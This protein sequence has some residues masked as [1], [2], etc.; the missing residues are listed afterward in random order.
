VKAQIILYKKLIFILMPVLILVIF[1]EVRARDMQNGFSV[2]KSMF[3][4]DMGNTE[5]LILGSSHGYFSINPEVF[6]IHSY[7]LAF[8]SQ[9]LY[10]D[11]ELLDK[12]K[13]SLKNLRCIMLSVSYFSL[14]YDLNEAPERWRKYFYKTYYNINPRSRLSL[15]DVTDAKSYSYAFFYGF[16]NVLFGM[17]DRKMFSFGSNMNSYGWN[18]DTLNHIIDSTGAFLSKGKGR[19]DFT[20]SLINK[21]NYESNVLLIEKLIKFARVRNI[22]LLFITTPVSYPYSLFADKNICREFQ[23]KISDYTDGKNIY[24]L[25]YFNDNRFSMKEYI[26]FDHLNG[27]GA[28]KFSRILKDTIETL[29][30]LD[31]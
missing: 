24:Y 18:S 16:E 31:K 12:Y 10:Y 13:G 25:N 1:F 29:K 9:D 14:W 19:V 5:L 22:K 4:S 23:K 21:D 8:N 7:N 20:N 6:N 3:E 15:S 11:F 2:K 26:D 27:Q 28:M 17:I 30:L